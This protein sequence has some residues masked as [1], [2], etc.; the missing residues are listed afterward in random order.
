MSDGISVQVVGD[1]LKVEFLEFQ[2][3]HF[4]PHYHYT[5][6]GSPLDVENVT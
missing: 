3:I 5:P 6:V 4:R 2:L 1:I